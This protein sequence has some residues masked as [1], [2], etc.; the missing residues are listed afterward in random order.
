MFRIFRATILNYD[1]CEYNLR[2]HIPGEL[3]YLYS[4][5]DDA[6]GNNMNDAENQGLF[7]VVR[8]CVYEVYL[9]RGI[10]IISVR[11]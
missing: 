2:V 10:Y 1:K 5:G 11:S 6:I 8:D 3:N 7:I 4:V 9:Y